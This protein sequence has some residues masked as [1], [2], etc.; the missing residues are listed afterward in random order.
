MSNFP[1]FFPAALFLF[2]AV[3]FVNLRRA[4]SST[5]WQ[6]PL[7]L[8][9]LF[10]TVP[11]VFHGARGFFMRHPVVVALSYYWIGFIILAATAFIARDL[12]S[13]AARLL[14]KVAGLGVTRFFGK[15]SVVAAFAIGIL[16]YGYSLYEARDVRVR[17]ITM[18]TDK[19]PE[20][21][22]GVRIVFMSDI[23]I[24]H[25]TR[26]RTLEKLRDM[27]NNQEAD[28]LVL[29]GDVV[30]GRF[31]P[32]GPQA[33]V[34][35]DMRAKVEKLAVVGNHELYAGLGAFLDFIDASG[36][37]TLRGDVVD[38]AGIQIVGVDD[39]QVRERV[40]IVDAL[41]KA[42]PDRFILLVSHRPDVPP[43]AIGR[44]DLSLSGHT[45]GGQVWPFGLVA[46]FVH[47]I[48]QGATVKQAPDG[49]PRRE[50]TLYVSNGTL[51]WGP[52]VR[53]LTPP[54]MTVVEVVREEN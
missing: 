52:P 30:D 41:A 1:I 33:A 42:D 21:S 17:T 22:P 12:L 46:E 54:E 11:W 5:W 23:H 31:S 18:R 38:V 9:F 4:F 39:T 49:A 16:A 6:W 44:Y 29:G 45:H 3:L 34:L 13:L 35:R 48:G 47:G 10:V 51:T 53:F 20:G 8:A 43:E 27:A 7:A 50:S 28:I 37:Q 25:T 15:K 19:L 26:I 36:F 40:E 14:D 32:A 2:H 24:T